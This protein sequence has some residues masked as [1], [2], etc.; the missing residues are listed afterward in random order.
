[1]DR[2]RGRIPERCVR[3]VALIREAPLT[4]ARIEPVPGDGIAI[5]RTF[6]KYPKL[7]QSRTGS[8]YVNQG[9]KLDPR[10]R[11]LLIL[12]TGW[13]CQAEYEWAQH[14]G[15]V[16][17]GRQMGLPIERIAM[18]PDAPGWDP[19]DATLL[20][21]ADELYRDSFISDRTWNALAA[22]FDNT[23][24]M[25]ASSQRRTIGWC[26]WHSMPWASSSTPVTRD[27]R[28][29][30]R[31][32]ARCVGRKGGVGIMKIRSLA[33]S[34]PVVV[35]VISA[36]VRTQNTAHSAALPRPGFHHLHLKEPAALT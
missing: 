7:A 10:Y 26:R 33:L 31:D 9:S 17:R 23:M 32:D 36:V 5:G 2:G 8:N 28:R 24:M 22:R 21:A 11:E 15:A 20:R 35:V 18:G 34:M 19:F 25:N 27:S 4:V 12:R 3:A 6:A 29:Y 16:G 30:R 1:L 13:D 14:V